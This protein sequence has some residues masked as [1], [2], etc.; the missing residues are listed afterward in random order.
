MSIIT[1]WSNKHKK[2]FPPSPRKLPIIGN[3]HQVVGL[4]PHR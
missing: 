2:N 3:L 4:L 1:K